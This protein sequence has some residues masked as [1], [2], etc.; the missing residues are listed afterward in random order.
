[1]AK[2]LSSAL[3]LITLLGT[4]NVLAQWCG[5][6]SQVDGKWAYSTITGSDVAWCQQYLCTNSYWGSQISGCPGS[7]PTCTDRVESQTV[8]CPLNQIGSIT[9]TRTY[10]CQTQSYTPWTASSN[11]CAPAP[12]TCQTSI[13]SQSSSCPVNYS[14][15]ITQTRSS[16][17]PD[18]YGQP[19]WG[20]WQTQNNCTQNPP[21]CQVATDSKTESCGLHYSGAKTYTKTSTCP[22][23]YGQ[24][25]QGAWSLVSNTCVQDPPSCK[26]VTESQ[27]LSCQTGY[28]GSIIQTRSSTCPDPYGQPVMG[29]WM[30]TTDACVKS[31]TNPTNP[32]SPVSPINPSSPLSATRS[33]SP[34]AP[35][36]PTPTPM[37]SVS[38]VE[39]VTETPK[40]SAPAVA[41]ATPMQSQD[42]QQAQTQNQ[43]PAPK[44]KTR[45]AGFGLVLSLE[46]FGKKPASTL[47]M[48]SQPSMAQAIPKE[49][50]RNND[51]LMEL[52]TIKPIDQSDLFEDIKNKGIEY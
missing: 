52:L 8:S 46:L 24:P 38:P 26:T 16:S 33:M 30:T 45:V 6:G 7:T 40:Q 23:P 12:A 11:S 32:T 17:C 20:S 41:A 4:N 19:V 10:Q 2:Y 31:M 43:A 50:Q 47:D 3:L 9:Q 51:L 28:T 39:S 44:G 22:D 21:S 14:G 15:S 37:A 25:V 35:T 27:T 13:E 1:M 49:M 18:P 42:N 34:S 5:L 36:Q 29:P 48:L